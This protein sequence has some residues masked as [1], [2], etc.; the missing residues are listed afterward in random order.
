MVTEAATEPASA[1]KLSTPFPPATPDITASLLQVLPDSHDGAGC[2]HTD[3]PS[4]GSMQSNPVAQA[5]QAAGNAAELRDSATV[6]NGS[7]PQEDLL[8]VHSCHVDSKVSPV[9]AA[10]SAPALEQ[11]AVKHTSQVDSQV[12]IPGPLQSGA[13]PG[14]IA[15]LPE[16]TFRVPTAHGA[17]ATS[18][19]QALTDSL[20]TVAASCTLTA[21]S[22]AANADARDPQLSALG[23]VRGTAAA[24]D[25]AS[26]A[27]TTEALLGT[28]P[29]S[30]QK[31][32]PCMVPAEQTVLP[33]P[34]AAASQVAP[35][36]DESSAAAETFTS[37]DTDMQ[38][39]SAA[40]ADGAKQPADTAPAAVRPESKMPLVEVQASSV[41][42]TGHEQQ[43]LDTHAHMAEGVYPQGQGTKGR[44]SR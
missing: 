23:A 26:P 8:S 43:D 20:H 28:E 33:A 34:T 19:T 25:F 5:M 9:K 1:D 27:T 38:K 40:S 17:A 6:A 14:S 3:I 4:H 30:E 44:T 15:Q 2:T 12:C 11:L 16:Q 39:S 22:D 42:G 37:A 24:D 18:S 7:L 41:D 10:Q 29:A 13:A 35:P 36:G 21:S 31:T 32:S